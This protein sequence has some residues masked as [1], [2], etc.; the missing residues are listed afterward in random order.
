MTHGALSSVSE[1][2]EDVESLVSGEGDVGR[3]GRGL[4]GP[5]QRAGERVCTQGH[6][7]DAGRARPV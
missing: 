5:A 4:S 7:H 6:E 1:R 2:E 3:G